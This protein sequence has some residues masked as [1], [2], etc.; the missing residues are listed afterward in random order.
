MFSYYYIAY[1]VT[2][3]L[4]K[5]SKNIGVGVAKDS[6]N[7]Y[8]IVVDYFPAGNVK[9]KFISNLPD[10]KTEDIKEA[11]EKEKQMING[12][13]KFHES[14]NRGYLGYRGNVTPEKD[15]PI[16]KNFQSYKKQQNT[17]NNIRKE[18]SSSSGASINGTLPGWRSELP[19]A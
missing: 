5:E 4:W 19:R 1:P 15:K 6:D 13:L 9:N 16:G 8:Y 2:Q 14:K 10:F 7:V 12:I 17:Q 3:I 18:N 11:I